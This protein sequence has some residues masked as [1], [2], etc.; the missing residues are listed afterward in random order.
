VARRYGQ[1]MVFVGL[2]MGVRWPYGT[3]TKACTIITT[4]ANPTM[5][6]PHDR[7]PVIL[8]PNDWPT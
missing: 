5:A 4:E 6:E 8:E 1:P 7:M 3:V 2:R